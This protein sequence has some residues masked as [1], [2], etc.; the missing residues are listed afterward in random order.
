MKAKREREMSDVPSSDG[1]AP[2]YTIDSW[3]IAKTAV[4]LWNVPEW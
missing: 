3:E 1:L 2:V 4:F